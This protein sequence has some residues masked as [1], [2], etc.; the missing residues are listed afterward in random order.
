MGIGATRTSQSSAAF[1]A[2]S[3]KQHYP[4]GVIGVMYFSIDCKCKLKSNYILGGVRTFG[5]L[6]SAS[7]SVPHSF[8]I[9]SASLA[10]GAKAEIGEITPA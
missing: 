6:L 4:N 3:A 10:A 5:S 7:L 1:I 2:A 8:L 9:M